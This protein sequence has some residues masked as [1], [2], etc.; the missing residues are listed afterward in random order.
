MTVTE[1]SYR[2][3][4]RKIVARALGHALPRKAHV[5]H[6]D[7]D[8]SNNSN[9]NLVACEDMGYHKLLHLRTAAFQATGNPHARKCMLCDVWQVPGTG[10]MVVVTR[11]NRPSGDGRAR[12]LSCHRQYEAQRRG[13][14]NQSN[15]SV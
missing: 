9:N 10:D 15:E 13:V 4:A 3:R 11:S 8:E 12:H 14:D 6:V 5:H 1:A 7:G 2:R